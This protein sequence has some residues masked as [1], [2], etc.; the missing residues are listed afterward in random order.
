MNAANVGLGPVLANNL[1]A[2]N[3]QG[4]IRVSGDTANVNGNPPRTVARI[5]NNTLHGPTNANAPASG[6]G[7]QINEGAVPT[8]VNNIISKFC[9]RYP[10]RWA[11]NWSTART[12]CQRLP[13]QCGRQEPCRLERI[14]P[15]STSERALTLFTDSTD[16]DS[17]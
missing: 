13:K 2:N 4:G 8:I 6:V 3:G 11:N 7:I 1:L 15:H 9:N 5:I 10:I 12:R 14:V 17:I 16:G